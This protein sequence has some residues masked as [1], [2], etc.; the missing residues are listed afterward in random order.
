MTA[1]SRTKEVTEQLGLGGHLW[2]GQYR[3]GGRQGNQRAW[4]TRISN[5]QKNKNWVAP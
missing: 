5:A 2:G 3:D 4:E 1:L